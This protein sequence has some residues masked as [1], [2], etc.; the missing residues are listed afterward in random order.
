MIGMS[1]NTPQKKD[2]INCFPTRPVMLTRV[3]GH[4]AIANQKA[5]DLAGIQQG[6]TLTGGEVEEKDGKLTGV[7]ID[8]AVDLVSSKIPAASPAQVKRAL[9]QAQQNCFAMGLTTVDDCGLDYREVLTI[10]SLQKK[11]ELKMRV[12]AMLSDAKQNYD[13]IFNKGKIKTDYLKR[14]LI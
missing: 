12:Y 13:Y 6:F 14:A 3:D 7:L 8:N 5:L 2:W 9:D 11:G 4:A 10:D 1:N